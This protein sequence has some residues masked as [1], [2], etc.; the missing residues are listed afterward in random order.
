MAVLEQ[1]A[2]LEAR[3]DLTT[4]AK[5]KLRWLL[6]SN[7][8]RDAL[9]PLVGKTTNVNGL[10]VTLGSATVDEAGFLYVDC[11]ITAGGVVKHSGPVRVGDIPITVINNQGN[12][13]EDLLAAGKAFLTM[14]A[15]V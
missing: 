9:L 1:V 10:S 11:L 14:L 5:R 8:V 6:K 4:G 7:G 13:V 15:S 12:E 2:A 3:T